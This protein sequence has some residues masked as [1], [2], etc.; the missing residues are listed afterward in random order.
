MVE[1]LLLALLCLFAPPPAS[2]HTYH[3]SPSGNDDASGLSPQTAWRSLTR[4]SEHNFEPGDSLLLRG[5]ATFT[6]TLSLSQEDAGTPTQPVFVASSGPERARLVN[7][8]TT[9]LSVTNAS[10]IVV[11]N[12]ILEGIDRTKNQGFGLRVL[13]TLPNADKRR[14][15][16]VANVR[17]SGFGQDGMWLGGAP[18]DGSQSGFE[19][20]EISGCEFFDNQYHGLFVTGVWDTNAKG[21]ANRRLHVH[22]CTAYAN[23]GDP[24]F[25]KNHSGSGM[26]IDDVEEATIEYCTAYDNGFLCNAH[27]GG[28]CGIW[29]H[30]ATRSVIQHCVAINNRTG[31]GIDGAGFD[32]DGGT[33]YCTIQYCYARDNDGAGILVWNY[34]NA[35]HELA[36]NVIRFNI[37][38]N[39]ARR[40]DYAAVHIGS[41]GTPVKD[42]A[43]YHNTIFTSAQPGGKA[44]CVWV[45]GKPNETIRFFNNLFLANGCPLVTLDSNQRVQFDGNAYWRTNGTFEASLATRRFSTFADWQRTSGQEKGG[46]F[47]EPGLTAFGTAETPVARANPPRLR[48][49]GLR[50][51]SVLIGKGLVLAPPGLTLGERDFFGKK[52]AGRFVGAVA[53]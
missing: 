53:P 7:P 10:G 27:V 30:A 23:T 5:G 34:E 18:A 16:R 19:D 50:K 41:S 37:L 24:L 35:P 38:E 46:F 51:T 47:A 40:N 22:H 14:F 9:A 17:A 20:V 8:D 3:L 44:R 13:N 26:E 33:T 1:T 29:L 45:G 42:M 31:R 6:G 28:P 39:N 12:L 36:H 32:L 21:Y 49:Y 43:V 4:A 11:E 15:I 48:G 2:R 52:P 25:L